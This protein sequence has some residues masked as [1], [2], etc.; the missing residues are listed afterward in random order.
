M[1][2]EINHFYIHVPFCI[3]KCGYCSFFSLEFSDSRK[4]TYI[5]YLKIEINE[6]IQRYDFNPKTIYFG[7]GTPSLLSST[8]INKIL[9]C[10][11]INEYREVTIETNPITITEEYAASL[12]RTK[13]NRISLGAQSFIEKELKLLGRLHNSAQIVK[14]V[15]VLRKHTFNNI[16]LDLMY[17]L[18]NQKLADVK[19]SLEKIIELQPEHISTY[20]LSLEEDV[21]L[22]K[23]KSM[24]PGDKTVSEFYYLILDELLKAGYQQYE[25]S[26]F[27]I[28]GRESKHNL[29]YWNDKSYLGFGPSA[30]G[31]VNTDCRPEPFDTTLDKLH[32]RIL[33]Y[34]N[35][36]DFDGYC[37]LIQTSKVEKHRNVRRSSKCLEKDYSHD[38][39]HSEDS[40]KS[41]HSEVITKDDHEKE[42]IFLAL[43]KTEGLNLNRFNETFS[44]D[45]IQKYSLIL[46][47][48]KKYIELKDGFAKLT[49]TAYFVSNEILSEFM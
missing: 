8:E 4:E 1:K 23:N 33:R 7:G 10:F 2:Q 49:P 11:E 19:Y 27:S 25:I 37:N 43:R 12:K 26:N 42:Y 15:E 30:A 39:Q 22:F 29:S 18:P 20:C 38:S 40:T 47:K 21:P 44:V 36:A 35:P 31:Y 5:D 32:R 45:F 14:A 48:Y 6:Y 28:E 9:S 24:I 41:K 17:G 13:I 34:T 16:S 3:R 46:L